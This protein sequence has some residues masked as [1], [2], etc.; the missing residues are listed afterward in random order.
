[1][2][3]F[4]C[5][6][7]ERERSTADVLSASFQGHLVPIAAQ[8]RRGS[9]VAFYYANLCFSK[10]LSTDFL[11]GIFMNISI[12]YKHTKRKKGSEASERAQTQETQVFPVSCGN[13]WA[14][15]I[16]NTE[17]SHVTYISGIFICTP[18]QIYHAFLMNQFLKFLY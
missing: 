13:L 12:T 5:T 15:S 14:H 10:F 16:K 2:L 4:N 7:N 18:V 3:T 11:F 8:L 17:F 1:M 9:E 6:E